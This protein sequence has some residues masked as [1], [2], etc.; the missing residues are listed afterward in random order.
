M[1]STEKTP[2]TDII[3]PT[4]AG[5]RLVLPATWIAAAVTFAVVVWFYCFETRFGPAHTRSSL[6]WLLSAW[7]PAT[8]Y[9]HGKL[10]PF[11]IL[12]LIF[13]RFKD[14]RASISTGSLWGLLFVILGCL[15][16]IAA[17]RTL[18]PRISVGGLPFIVWG[19]VLFL[20]GW[21]TAKLTLFPLFFFWI[22]IPLPAF[23]QATVHLQLI[24]TQLA[25]HGS[26]LFGVETYTQG[27]LVLPV[28]GDWKPLEIAHGC[29][30]IRSLMALLMISAAWAYVA[31]MAL[32]KRVFLFLSAVPLAIVGNALRVIS[33]FIIAEYGDAKWASTTWH[34][35]SGLLLFYPFS[36]MMLLGI[37]TLLEGGLPWKHANRRQM[38]RVTVTSATQNQQPSQS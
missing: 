22:A 26:G 17:Y 15:F 23:Q 28:H 6:G 32:W 25:H 18:Q 5:G 14:L 21:R 30:G 29:S 36:L 27:T 13:Y 34:D 9:E 31:K 19:A 38:R 35:W 12:G 37:N 11:I 7:N 33:I 20:W 16:H 10:I 3:Q 1:N 4:S 2:K 24:A 8:D